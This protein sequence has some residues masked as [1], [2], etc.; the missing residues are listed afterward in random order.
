MAYSS[1]SQSS[2]SDSQSSASDS[3]LPSKPHKPLD[4]NFPKRSYGQKTPV[5]R[6]IQPCWLVSGHFYIMMKPKTWYSATRLLGFKKNKM[7]DAK[8]DPAFVSLY[9]T[10]AET[11][12]A[13]T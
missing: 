11:D 12:V 10:A 7:R 8:V 13:S 3:F 2:A 4:F 1:A 9:W 6:S 5:L